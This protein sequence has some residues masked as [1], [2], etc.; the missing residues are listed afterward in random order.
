[1]IALRGGLA[2]WHFGKFQMGWSIFSLVGLSHLFF[3]CK[4]IMIWVVMGASRE[5]IV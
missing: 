5:K 4:M 2:I 3:F 1:M